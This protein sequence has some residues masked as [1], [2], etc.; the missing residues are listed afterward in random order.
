MR[1]LAGSL[2]KIRLAPSIGHHPMPS[3]GACLGPTSRQLTDKQTQSS[4][5]SSHLPKYQRHKSG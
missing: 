2:G 4:P 3:T 5:Q 1:S